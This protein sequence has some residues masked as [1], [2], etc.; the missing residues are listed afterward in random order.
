MTNDHDTSPPR[1][2]RGFGLATLLVVAVLSAA[3]AVAAVLIV[4]PWSGEQQR[5][6]ASA[7]A[8]LYHCPM[9]PSIVQD[10][11]GDCPICGMKLVE[12][13]AASAA[14]APTPGTAPGSMAAGGAP[15]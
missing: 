5:P 4:H 2:R 8:T 1:T 13:S 9:H 14:G 12:V 3:A 6:A 10:H 15:A 11:P 7:P